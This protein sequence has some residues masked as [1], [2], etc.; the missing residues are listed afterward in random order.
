[1]PLPLP[2]GDTQGTLNGI[3]CPVHPCLHSPTMQS[4]LRAEKRSTTRKRLYKPPVKLA[5]LSCRASR[6]RCDGQEPCSN[7]ITKRRVCLY[8][9]S[10]RGRPTKRTILPRSTKSFL[11]E[12]KK[13]TPATPITHLTGNP[14]TGRK[15]QSV[16]PVQTDIY[17][18]IVA[19]LH[20][21]ITASS[22]LNRLSQ[23]SQPKLLRSTVRLYGSEQDILAAYYELI[24]PSF[25]VLPP[26]NPSFAIYQST[27]GIFDHISLFELPYR[28]RSALSLAIA[29]MLAL[30]PHPDDQ[31]PSSE[32]SRA[33]RLM[34]SRALSQLAILSVETD[35]EF[36]EPFHPDVPVSLEKI[37]ALLILS[38]YEYLHYGS[39]QKMQYRAGQALTLALD[40]SLDCFEETNK[41]AE[42]Q[43]RAWWM[44]Y[45][46]VL[47]GRIAGESL[48]SIL[49]KLDSSTPYPRLS[50]DPNG[51]S[52][53]IESQ[54][55]LALTAQLASDLDR[56]LNGLEQPF[57]QHR[58]EEV[59]VKINT[60]LMQSQ[61]LPIGPVSNTPY[62]SEYHVALNIRIISRIKLFSA[63]IKVYQ[64]QLLLCNKANRPQRFFSPENM[65]PGNFTSDSGDMLIP[66]EI[67]YTQGTESPLLSSDF[68]AHGP[69]SAYTHIELRTSVEYTIKS[70]LRAA[71]AICS[72]VQVFHD[73]TSL[74]IRLG[75]V[76]D[77]HPSASDLHP[78]VSHII[79]PAL[80][81]GL[82]QASDVISKIG[83]KACMA[84]RA[85]HM[86]EDPAARTSDHLIAALRQSLECVIEILTHNSISFE[87]FRGIADDIK[88]T[89][90][91][92]F[93]TRIS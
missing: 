17:N 67:G 45:Y 39:P 2:L 75:A 62:R 83:Y 50:A 61:F 84:Q 35:C 26:F 30:I 63:Q 64:L 28:P 81:F 33:Y 77:S 92:A 20:L 88:S 91:R 8:L 27:C 68:C 58:L 78:A 87:A 56:S 11:Q 6:V 32:K 44:T 38:I 51:W 79:A 53:L 23:L 73:P 7:C 34:Y 9:P 25:P 76:D 18:L 12:V 24:H 36:Q 19:L 74:L 90:Y 46:C 80:A 93:S 47:Q 54:R 69:V 16:S 89:N 86:Q 14:T 3:M 15:T 1:M 29:S 49:S 52:I 60:L 4:Q 21:D 43:R 59:Y 85:S 5:C 72:M 42:A 41:Y 65:D 55:A 82:K 40:K 22:L 70:L 10:Q 57:I 31:E 71:L 13:S 37:I 48:P 66:S